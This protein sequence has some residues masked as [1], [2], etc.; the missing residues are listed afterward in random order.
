MIDKQANKQLSKG[1]KTKARKPGWWARRSRRKL[2]A[3]ILSALENYDIK[4]VWAHKDFVSAVERR[5][6]NVT[7]YVE[8]S[9]KAADGYAEKIGMELDKTIKKQAI[10]IIDVNSLLPSVKEFVFK[11]VE[12]VR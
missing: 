3:E 9:A 5:P 11:D 7:M 2:L 4:S 1:L 10:N 12:Q 8:F 6:K